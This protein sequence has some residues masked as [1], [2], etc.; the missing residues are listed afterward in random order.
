MGKVKSYYMREELRDAAW[1]DLGEYYAFLA[2]QQQEQ[3]VADGKAAYQLEPGI[4]EDSY[5]QYMEGK[6][7]G[8]Q[9]NTAHTDTGINSKN[10]L[11]NTGEN[12]I[13]KYRKRKSAE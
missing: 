3:D 4:E 5:N 9:T 10:G 6:L 1:D 8:E 13:L 2:E 7:C 11:S 12:A